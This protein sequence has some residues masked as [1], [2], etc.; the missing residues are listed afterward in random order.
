M[1][2]AAWRHQA[3]LAQDL[4]VGGC[5]RLTRRAC[6]WLVRGPGVSPQHQNSVNVL[7]NTAPERVDRA[8]WS[9]R[10]EG[11]RPKAGQ[12]PVSPLHGK[13]T[14]RQPKTGWPNHS[15]Q[16]RESKYN[17]PTGT[18]EQSSQQ[19]GSRRT[20]GGGAASAQRP[21]PLPSSASV[22]TE[23]DQ[24]QTLIPWH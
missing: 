18:K 5:G 24:P 10:Y 11:N 9:I 3:S 1:S 20:P 21:P 4:T 15:T 12:Q 6:A 14:L 23:P 13:G 8:D 22:P 16:F 17:E 7:G 2:A 19:Q